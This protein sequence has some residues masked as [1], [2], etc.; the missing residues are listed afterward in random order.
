MLRLP[1]ELFEL[2]FS[3]LDR[4]DL[5]AL[6][7]VCFRLRSLA[8]FPFFARYNISEQHI[9]SGTPSVS[10]ESCFLIIVVANICPI[11]KLE[12]LRGKLDHR[13]DD[14]VPALSAVLS[15]VPPIPDVYLRTSDTTTKGSLS[16]PRILSASCFSKKPTLVFV[17]HHTVS[18]SLH[19]DIVLLH[20]ENIHLLSL[21][22]SLAS[23]LCLLVAS[24]FQGSLAYLLCH[25]ILSTI[26]AAWVYLTFTSLSNLERRIAGDLGWFNGSWIHVQSLL[27]GTD[28]QFTLVTFG[29]DGYMSVTLPRLYGLT[30]AQRSILLRSLEIPGDLIILTIAEG[31]N[32]TLNDV[33]ECIRRHAHLSS[34]VF[35][36][37]SI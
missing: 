7:R 9:R 6:V 18:V 22:I 28:G 1:N 32:F 25:V 14:L 8:L 30:A 26:A 24:L 36:A 13:D 37:R 2:L 23:L 35:E 17:S 29:N 21:V 16:I 31:A 4:R 19:R 15:A 3:F 33:M 10:V 5:W 12:V 27:A 11:R 34:V 20:L